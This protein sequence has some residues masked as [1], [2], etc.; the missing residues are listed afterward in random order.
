MGQLFHPHDRGR[1]IADLDGLAELGGVEAF[2]LD[3]AVGVGEGRAEQRHALVV[4]EACEGM[5]DLDVEVDVTFQHLGLAGPAVTLAATVRESEPAA[6][7]R[8]QHRLLFAAF[9]ADV[10]R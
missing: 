2:H 3:G 4:L 6:D 8:L 10:G 5:G 9:E 1:H 7:G